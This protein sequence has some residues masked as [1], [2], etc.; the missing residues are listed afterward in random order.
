MDG[1]KL[2]KVKECTDE[3]LELMER[4]N[5]KVKKVSQAKTL[6]SS[7]ERRLCDKLS[8]EER[9]KIREAVKRLEEAP[10]ER[11]SEEIIRLKEMAYLLE[12]DYG[13]R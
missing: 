1:Y 7:V 11:V 2:Q 5:I 9:R 8:S 4:V 6:L 12:A 3:L 10:Y 13:E